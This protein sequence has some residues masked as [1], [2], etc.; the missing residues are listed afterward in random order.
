MEISYLEEIAMRYFARI[1][2]A[3]LGLLFFGPAMATDITGAG[4]SFVAP[5]M[6]K[7][8][9]DY[10]TK[11]GTLVTYRS[12]GSSGG[13]AEI[14]AGTVDFGASDAPLKPREL[15]KA[16]LAQFPLV[17]G[18][19][20][21]VLNV[22]GL[23]PGELKLTGPMLADIFL[24][25]IKTWNDPAIVALN[26]GSKL[27]SAPIRIVHRI[28]GSGTTFN[29]TNYLA[30][31]SPDWQAKI[32]AGLAVDWP[33]GVGG[34]GNEGVTAL[35]QQTSS[36]IG[37]VEYAYALKNKLVYALV[38]N[39]A[40]KFATPGA[41]SFQA[42]ASS[43]D[44]SKAADFD[45]VIT[46]APRGDAYPIAATSFVL[47]QRSP[48]EA[49]RSRA[50]LDFFRWAFTNGQKQASDLDY[51]SLPQPLVGQIET[52]WKSAFTPMN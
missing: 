39:R 3:A 33:L 40:Q 48:T 27:P 10:A 15:Q 25:K 20:V 43:A 32:G 6:S 44:W 4:S 46:D 37:Y 26:A 14:K 12:I 11:S 8:A 22:Q 47:M 16:G 49:A 9:L 28:D 2:A 19:V 34:K 30:K 51:V 35:V 42:A 24:G 31:V 41:A 7:W 17:I 29:W 45:V 1:A 18:G 52:Y 21:P 36:S 50:A 5:V 13:I 38:Q 23:A